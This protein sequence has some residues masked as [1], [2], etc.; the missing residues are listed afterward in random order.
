MAGLTRTAG[1]FA[2]T[3]HKISL[4]VL[5]QIY[6]PSAQISLPF[7]FSS[8]SQHNRLGLYLLSLF[9]FSWICIY[10]IVYSA[11][12]RVDENLVAY[13]DSIFLLVSVNDDKSVDLEQLS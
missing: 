12:L 1:G 2:V 13:I 3:P 8:V 6:A 11:R 4:C 9:V 7:P 10:L 5:L